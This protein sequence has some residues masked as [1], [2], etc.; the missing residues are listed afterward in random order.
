MALKYNDKVQISRQKEIDEYR[1]RIVEILDE[2]KQ[3][4][5][6]CDNLVKLRALKTRCEKLSKPRPT[7]KTEEAREGKRKN[8]HENKSR[9]LEYK[10]EKRKKIRQIGQTDVGSFFGGGV[11]TQK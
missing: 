11:P 7:L 4:A 1:K 10:G 9:Y 5:T 3:L 6:G 8:Y 2:S